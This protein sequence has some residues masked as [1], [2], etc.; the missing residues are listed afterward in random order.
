MRYGQPIHNISWYLRH[1]CK[2]KPLNELILDAFKWRWI[3]MKW[4]FINLFI[5]FCLCISQLTLSLSLFGKKNIEKSRSTSSSSCTIKKI[6]YS[7]YL[8]C[9]HIYVTTLYQSQGRRVV[10]L[11]IQRRDDEYFL[12]PHTTHSERRKVFSFIFFLIKLK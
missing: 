4:I 2:N 8:L 7:M 6:L 1:S 11:L 12:L 5:L 10:I 9:I 3:I